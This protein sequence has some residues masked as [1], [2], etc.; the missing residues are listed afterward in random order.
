MQPEKIAVLGAGSWGTAMAIS[1]ARH[2]HQITLWGHDPKHVD[3]LSKDRC[4]KEFLPGFDFPEAIKLNSSLEDTLKTHSFIML[5]V[6]SH[7]FR[8]T[9]VKCKPHLQPK[10]LVSWIT[11]GFETK[12][13][14]LAHEVIQEELGKNTRLALVSGPS[15]A[16]EV[17]DD[18]P[19]AVT[20][21]SPDIKEAESVA[22]L[23]RGPHFLTFPSADIASAE[24]GGSIKNILAIAAGISDGVGYGANARAALITRGLA[25]MVQLGNL[26]GCSESSF[27]DLAGI[28]DLVLTCTDDKSRNR[29]MGLKLG[30]GIGRAAAIKQIGQEVEG[31]HAAREVYRLIKK[32]HLDMPICLQVYR[33]LFEDLVPKDAVRSLLSLAQNPS[34]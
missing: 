18:L 6:P 11:K 14:L 23:L 12:T 9:L 21:A 7:A 3:A 5:G 26:Y 2:G 30:K 4:N 19:T 16:L 29:R 15:F 24:I 1:M 33:I 20:V 17:A 22:N 28:G 13:G 31:V 25:E 32:H 34:T 27:L 8:E 10:T